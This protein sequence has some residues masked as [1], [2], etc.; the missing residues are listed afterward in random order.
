MSKPPE[1]SRKVL[2]KGLTA[3]L[4]RRVA[5]PEEPAPPPAEAVK[6]LPVE[7]IEPNPLQP[8]RVFQPERLQELAQSIQANGIIQPLVVRLH[9]GQYQLVAGERRWRAAKIAGLTVVPVVVEEIS[10]DHLLEI[11][12]VENIQREDLNPIETALAFQRLHR[13]LNLNH[14]EI[15]RRTG[16]DRTTITNLLRLLQLPID[17]QQ[18]V[19]DRRLS[20]GH[21]RCLIGLPESLQSEIAEKAVAQGMSVRQLEH[22]TQRMT[23]GRKA[24]VVDDPAADPNVRAALDEL[25]RKLGTKVR[26]V[27]KP[28]GKGRLEIE[29]YSADDLDR[30][31]T[32]IVGDSTDQ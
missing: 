31:Y 21:A 26:I 7:Q 15:G 10:D 4:P 17:I 13:E 12:L 32:A 1:G 6:Q 2:G 16:K 24:K 27:G 29:Y 22:L 25:E 30:I 18:L 3:L 28:S 5:A 23:E 19:A 14:E 8:R 9:Q 11:T 20:Q